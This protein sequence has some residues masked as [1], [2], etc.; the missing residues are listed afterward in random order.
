MSIEASDPKSRT[1]GILWGLTKVG[2]T[3]FLSSLPPPILYVMLDPDGEAVLPLNDDRIHI[4]AL[5]EQEDATVVRFLKD[6]MPT[7]IKKNA[8][9][10]NS[11]V[12]DSATSLGRIILNL[13]IENEVG[14]TSRFTPTLDAPGLGAYGSRTNRLIDIVNVNL[15][16]TARVGAHCWF[17]A[18]EDEPKTNA[19]GELIYITMAQ[20]GKTINGMGLNVSEIWFMHITDKGKRSICIAPAY[21][22]KPMGSRMF[23]TS[24]KPDFE[25]KFDPALLSDQP[26][27]ITTWHAAWEKGERKKLAL[28]R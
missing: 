18:H 11:Y 4:M 12:F 1:T 14:A 15:R 23:D 27:S 25:L 22:H 9:V 20:S 6:K 17:T 2:K 3:T 5:Y 16:A 8:G 28:P 19:K 13:A 21:S 24:G 10:Y 7:F 26:H